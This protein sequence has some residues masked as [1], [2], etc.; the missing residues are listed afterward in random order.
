[1]ISQMYSVDPKYATDFRDHEGTRVENDRNLLPKLAEIRNGHNKESLERFAKAYLG[2]FLDID[3]NIPPH[4]RI[5]IL[6]NETLAQG[7][8][9]GFEAIL[10]Q[11]EFPDEAAIADAMMDERPITIGYILLAALDLFGDDPR[12]SVK[13]LP[14]TTIRAAICFH[15]AAKTELHDR[16]FIQVLQQRPNEVADAISPF[17]RQLLARDCDHL[18]G[19]YQFISHPQYDEISRRIIL[20]VLADLKHCRKRT[21]R[22]LLHAALRVC[23]HTELLTICENA[24]SH[25]NRADPSRYILWLATTFLL[26]PGK[27]DMLLADYC[28]RSKE[29]ILP[30]LDFTV[31]VLLTDDQ[32]RLPLHADTYT[33]LLRIIAAKFTPQL[34]RYGDLCDNTQKVM[35]LFY[36]LAMARDADTAAAIKRLGLVRVMKLY[37]HILAFVTELQAQQ[38]P[39]EFEEFL[40]LLQQHD[41]IKI[42]KKWSDLGH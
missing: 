17:W 36:R 29:K 27:Y 31:M 3:N 1:M 39:L 9:Q 8:L 40:A 12:Y 19:L 32:Q 6:A 41:S 14:A 7:V 38:R 11:G 25:W 2:M 30:L 20:P 10:V 26:Q 34:D 18:P 24:L 42:R 5:C 16:W 28:G 13:H 35:Y 15:F 22:D 23:D 4:D 37:K 33:L 21:L